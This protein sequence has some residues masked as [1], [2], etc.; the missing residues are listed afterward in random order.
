MKKIFSI[1]AL[2]ALAAAGQAQAAL[3]TLDSSHW[4]PVGSSGLQTVLFNRVDGQ[5][6]MMVALGAH[7]YKNGPLLP[8]DNGVDTF[9]GAML[10]TYAAE[11]RA[12]W[13]FDFAYDTGSCTNCTVELF[14]DA[15]PT[16]GTSFFSFGQQAV[17]GIGMDSWNLEMNFLEVLM[18]P[19]DPNAIGKYDFGLTM[20]SSETKSNELST[21]ISVETV[22]HVSEPGTLALAG[23]AVL[24]LG[25][26]RRRRKQGHT[27]PA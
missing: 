27:T 19:F 20:R 10:G 8:S 25:V 13:S 12:N 6:G 11:D 2:S 18:G 26:T 9:Y 3:V 17:N 1:L 4:P 21:Y 7:A 23:L 16:A 14:M 22:G 15:D 5:N 24:G